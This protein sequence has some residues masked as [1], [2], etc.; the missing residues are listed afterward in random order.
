MKPSSRLTIFACM[1]ILL[2]WPPSGL[3]AEYLGAASDAGPQLAFPGAEGFGRHALGGRGG[4]VY[5]VTNLDD[6]GP[7]SLRLGL[8][9]ADGPR[10]ILFRVSGTIALEST[11][12]VD[13]PYITIA[14]QSAPGDGITL[15]DHGLVVGNDHVIIRYIRSR[16]GDR[17]GR[18]DTAVRIHAGRNVILDH[19][20]ASWGVDEILSSSSPAYGS[21]QET[22]AGVTD[23]ITIQWCIISEGL[24][25]VPRVEGIRNRAFGSVIRGRRESL[26]HNLYAHLNNRGPKIAWRA[27]SKV[28]FRNNV[29]YNCP[30]R[31]SY[32][33]SNAYVNWANNYYK[34]GPNAG[35][36]EVFIIYQIWNDPPMKGELEVAPR[37]YVSGNHVEGYPALSEDNHLGI[38]FRKGAGPDSLVPAPHDFPPLHGEQPAAEAYLSVL[39]GAGASHA[40]DAIDR[41]LVEEVRQGTATYG[42]TRGAATGIIDS[43][44]DVGGWPVLRSLPPPSDTDGDGM[45]D[46]WE[47]EHGLDPGDSNDR[48]HDRTGDGYTNL[49]EYLNWLADPAGRL[50][51]HHPQ[52]AD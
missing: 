40:R 11:L 39:D 35:R 19:V 5:Y 18:A 49:E 3:R 45:P 17:A 20:T 12:S 6:G 14:G 52:R 9:S 34:P 4:D 51:D 48:N 37:F 26:H 29:I 41:R 15:R 50:L 25:N 44:E 36:P 16:L 24:Y 23:L 43:P 33:G 2:V 32:D 27:H 7:G 21:V 38:E 28:D 22:E 47:T 1:A 10:T 13:A 46:W 30:S 42:G 31:A 8:E